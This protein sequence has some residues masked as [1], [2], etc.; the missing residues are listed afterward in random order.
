MRERPREEFDIEH[1]S[2]GGNHVEMNL[3]LGVLELR[4]EAAVRA[5]EQALYRGP[6]DNGNGELTRTSNAT[7]GTIPLLFPPG[8]LV[9][10]FQGGDPAT[11]D[12]SFDGSDEAE[13]HDAPSSQG[14]DRSRRA[15]AVAGGGKKS[16][17]TGREVY[18]RPK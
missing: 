8:V 18:S 13:I 7:G 2:E 17:T 10:T 16:T 5:A 3:G 1:L 12:E 15:A 14:I 9:E 6:D 11:S 4:D